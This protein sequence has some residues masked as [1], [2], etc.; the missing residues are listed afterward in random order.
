MRPPQKLHNAKANVHLQ[1]SLGC[2][3]S[4]YWC[5]HFGS[6]LSHLAAALHEPEEW[7]SSGMLSPVALVITDVS[8][9]LSSY[10]SISSQRAS[11]AG[12]N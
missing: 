11:V 3:T 1:F 9:E 8:E 2:H 7:W 5:C 6:Y 4:R 12:Y 10:Q